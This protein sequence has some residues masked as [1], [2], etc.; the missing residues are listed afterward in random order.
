MPRKGITTGGRKRNEYRHNADGTTAIILRSPKYGNPEC[1]IDTEDFEAVSQYGWWARGNDTRKHGKNTIY[2]YTTMPHPNGGKVL[3]SDGVVR[4]RTTTLSLH[5]F[6]MYGCELIGER[7]KLQIDHINQNT[8]DN[9]KENLRW[10]THREN[11]MNTK[12]H[13]HN[14]TGFRGVSK[15]SDPSRQKLPYY[16]KTRLVEGRSSTRGCFATA[17]EAALCYDDLVR[18]HLNPEFHKG[19]LNFPDGPPPEVLEK[20]EKAREA[21]LE[22]KLS[23]MTSPFTGVGLWGK[24]D[25]KEMR[26]ADRPWRATLI[27][28]K[29]NY[30]VR[31]TYATDRE[32]AIARDK[33]II[34]YGLQDKKK[35]AF[36]E[37]LEEYLGATNNKKTID[38]ERQDGY[39]YVNQ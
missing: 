27:H 1:L 29:K 34:E 4:I 8:L 2:P 12:L 28:E 5:Q 17:E 26:K 10:A 7:R 9:R 18:E 6:I 31:G 30:T 15:L 13:S 11:A 21:H 25:S 39:A 37:L 19:A 32:A 33:A 24:R 38:I 22:E 35:L 20:A 23:K 14:T 36:P 16:V 3:N